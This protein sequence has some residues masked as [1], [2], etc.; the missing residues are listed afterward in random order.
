[1][2]VRGHYPNSTPRA[3]AL[4]CPPVIQLGDREYATPYP[5]Y[6]PCVHS[7]SMNAWVIENH[8]LTPGIN[9]MPSFAPTL[10]SF[11]QHD[12]TCRVEPCQSIAHTHTQSSACPPFRWCRQKAM[13]VF[14]G[15]GVAG[16]T[17]SLA[18]ATL[19]TRQEHRY[20]GSN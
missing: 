1:M 18:P 7:K 3:Y 14:K 11:S 8:V 19:R 12:S 9:F 6:Q 15:N 2:F 4:V 16:I 17:V 5:L 10:A 20:K 13:P